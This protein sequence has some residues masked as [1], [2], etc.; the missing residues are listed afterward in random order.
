MS[1]PRASALDRSMSGFENSPRRIAI[2]VLLLL[3]GIAWI[4]VFAK[5]AAPHAFWQEGFG[6]E[7]SNPIPWMAKL[8]L[9]NYLI[10]FGLIL[11]SLWVAAEKTTPL[12]RGRGVVIGMVGCLIV[13]LIWIVL[14]YLLGSTGKIPVMNHLGQW[15]LALGMAIIA[16][17]FAFATKWE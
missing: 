3:V 14:F 16:T 12:G 2:A 7:P 17:S 15:N 9:W 6:K 13:G 8:K 10:G 11:A 5:Y 4:V 1:K